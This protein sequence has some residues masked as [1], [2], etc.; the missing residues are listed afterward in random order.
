[1]LSRS[2][3]G[4]TLVHSD[5]LARKNEQQQLE[6]KTQSKKIVE[7]EDIVDNLEDVIVKYK[8]QAEDLLACQEQPVSSW[9]RDMVGE[10]E[11]LK[12]ELRSATISIE[13]M[14]RKC[15]KMAAELE[16]AST[17]EESLKLKIEEAQYQKNLM[18]MDFAKQ[19]KILKDFVEQ[20]MQ[21]IETKY[22]EC[23]KINEESSKMKNRI[24][25]IGLLLSDEERQDSDGCKVNENGSD[26][27]FKSVDLQVYKMVEN[28]KMLR[29]EKQELCELV[30]FLENEEA[31]MLEDT[32]NFKVAANE[33]KAEN[34]ALEMVK[35]DFENKIEFW[36][37]YCREL[38][39]SIKLE[40]Q[41]FEELKAKCKRVGKV[42]NCERA[43]RKKLAQQNKCLVKLLKASQANARFE[44]KL[45][46][47]L[48][49]KNLDLQMDLQSFKDIFES[50]DEKVKS[51]ILESL[52]FD[53]LV[54][55]NKEF[56]NEVQFL[57]SSLKRN[58][59]EL[60]ICKTGWERTKV[61]LDEEIKNKVMLGEKLNEISAK[62]DKFEIDVKNRDKAIYDLQH[63][64]SK[65]EDKVEKRHR[66][67]LSC[68][69]K[70]VRCSL[71]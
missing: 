66:P 64:I 11:E 49:A 23:E 51:G 7:L 63:E 3:S 71:G 16:T 68:L 37:Q 22:N 18:S 48:G 38:Y 21:E 53:Q 28:E 65:L 19:E 58:K 40:G 13:D 12:A 25:K 29:K 43:K 67:Q 30:E 60:S 31:I 44:T 26:D 2:D 27:V 46:N 47:T 34:N 70:F 9:M 39:H 14:T 54:E 33:L 4:L 17:Q 61:E 10:N 15:T 62:K 6:I 52:R 55:K 50:Y 45:K 20:L 69:Q 59:K 1:M 42:A 35:K 32:E 5:P 41:K 56:E 57:E 8:K 36:T 24:N